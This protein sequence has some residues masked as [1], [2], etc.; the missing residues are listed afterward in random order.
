M[1]NM[2]THITTPTHQMHVKDG[3]RVDNVCHLTAF[4]STK[5][6]TQRE[7]E[8]VKEGEEEAELLRLYAYA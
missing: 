6:A 8:R 7:P 2:K 4:Q 5:T 3:M 1:Y